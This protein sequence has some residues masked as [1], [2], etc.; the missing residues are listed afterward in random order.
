M[1]HTYIIPYFVRFGSCSVLA[2]THVQKHIRW[3]FLFLLFVRVFAF[4]FWKSRTIS[5]A[6]KIDLWTIVNDP[7]HWVYLLCPKLM[8]WIDKFN[9]RQAVCS[10][11]LHLHLTTEKLWMRTTDRTWRCRE[12]ERKRERAMAAIR[13]ERK[14]CL[15]VDVAFTSLCSSYASWIHKAML[16][17]IVSASYVPCSVHKRNGML[18]IKMRNAYAR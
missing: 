7:Y 12:K 4:R 13:T 2:F 15:C 9:T 8:L 1:I 3:L 6:R 14:I 5:M 10:S 11:H 16:K 17:W 18:C